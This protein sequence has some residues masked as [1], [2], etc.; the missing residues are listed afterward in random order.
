MRMGAGLLLVPLAASLLLVLWNGSQGA[1][2]A[3]RAHAN[4]GDRF[5]VG[6]ELGEL[7]QNGFSDLGPRNYTPIVGSIPPLGRHDDLGWR[8]VS[9]N[10]KLSEEHLR[11]SSFITGNKEG[12][13]R[14]LNIE[15]LYLDY[16]P[17]GRP[18][19][20]LSIAPVLGI[21]LGYN[22]TRIA[23]SSADGEAE[24]VQLFSPSLRG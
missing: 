22:Y 10:V 1:E 12:L 20:G 6:I 2:I 7:M 8:F 23:K 3:D 9:I 4:P 16:Y 17:F 19:G 21:G 5:Y 15:R 24:F 13:T 18:S 11:D 14:N